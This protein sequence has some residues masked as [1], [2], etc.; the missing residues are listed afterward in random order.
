MD[1]RLWT[2]PFV[3][4]VSAGLLD[5]VYMGLIV[6]SPTGCERDAF[7]CAAAVNL[8]S[9]AASTASRELTAEARRLR[10]APSVR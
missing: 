9:L 2:R 3:V 10:A 6:G 7:L 5:V 4:V 1:G 8:I